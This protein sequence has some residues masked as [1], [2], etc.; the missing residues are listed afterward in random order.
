MSDIEVGNAIRLDAKFSDLERGLASVTASIEKVEGSVRKLNE[1]SEKIQ[2][3][4]KGIF[5]LDKIDAYRGAIEEVTG[6]YVDYTKQLMDLAI[7]GDK[8]V[9]VGKQFEASWKGAST[10]LAESVSSLT[11]YR[12][13]LTESQQLLIR[14]NALHLD[15]Y[16]AMTL[17]GAT[18]RI[19]AGL[20][21]DQAR[22]QNAVLTAMETGQTRSL[23]LLHLSK[24]QKDSVKSTADLYNLIVAESEKYEA[25]TQ[26]AGR[27]ASEVQ[28]QIANAEDNL[29]VAVTESER[30]Q[31]SFSGIAA[32]AGF[33]AEHMD[34]VVSLLTTA[35]VSGIGGLLQSATELIGRLRGGS[36]SLGQ[37]AGIH[38]DAGQLDTKEFLAYQQSLI[39]GGG[40]ASALNKS[41]FGA[42]GGAD[43]TGIVDF[44]A[45][46]YADI[47]SGSAPKA[48]SGSAARAPTMAG[49]GSLGGYSQWGDMGGALG[50]LGGMA[51]ANTLGTA[52]IG[53]QDWGGGFQAMSASALD[54]A[55]VLANKLSPELEKAV[56]LQEHT[57][58]VGKQVDDAFVGI[59]A[60]A[61]GN[62]LD[63]ILAAAKGEE[64]FGMA[65]LGAV[66][67]TAEGIM[68]MA[69]PKSIFELAEGWADL[70]SPFT[71]PLA[72]A[73]F[74]AAGIF[75]GLA[76]GGFA[77][78]LGTGLAQSA[79]SSSSS[80]G[81]S[82][83][84]AAGVGGAGT[85]AATFLSPAARTSE[86]K[87]QGPAVVNNY[88][89]QGHNFSNLA[90]LGV[91]TDQGQK[92]AR[93]KGLIS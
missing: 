32:L 90:D 58:K 93:S 48:R 10:G 43:T 70:G 69:L 74:T 73:H 86:T 31:M 59:G 41:G 38:G 22:A 49:A 92:Q 62:F 82:S 91:V 40:A 12:L 15:Q 72:A 78:S 27:A 14:M 89:I 87:G 77:V 18:S 71:A 61:A 24:E 34:T 2:E 65:M 36:A 47:I 7:A 56:K 81:G 11:N 19:A 63:G 35:D 1:T 85:S 67:S 17:V 66:Q 53:N 3:A 44:E 16:Q 6:R 20:G 37:G 8:E 28:V 79:M 26:S 46:G 55:D 39:P 23:N 83:S 45:L 68:A 21:E 30:L 64:D 57:A 75:G 9:A 50:R 54:L 51:G 13:G 84:A 5:D 88:Y 29:A 42:G 80:S 25:S 76:A 4:T 60:S 52:G 33:V